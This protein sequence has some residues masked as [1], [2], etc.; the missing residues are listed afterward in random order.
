LAA[1]WL[2]MTP[3]VMLP[4]SRKLPLPIFRSDFLDASCVLPRA[5]Y[6]FSL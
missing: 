2:P 5:G 4:A 3:P 1:R 6:S